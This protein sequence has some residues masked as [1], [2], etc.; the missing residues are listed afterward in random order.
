MIEGRNQIAVEWYT[1]NRTSLSMVWYGT[2]A[3]TSTAIGGQQQQMMIMA[4]K[5]HGGQ[6]FKHLVLLGDLIPGINYRKWSNLLRRFSESLVSTSKEYKV[7]SEEM[8]SDV[9]YFKVPDHRL[10]SSSSSFT[11]SSSHL[12]RPK[13]IDPEE[14]LEAD[15]QQLEQVFAESARALDGVLSQVLDDLRRVD[16]LFD[17]G[18]EEDDGEEEEEAEVTKSN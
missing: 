18:L 9:H 11:F 4:D 2:R 15:D 8:V 1:R 3:F 7:G 5:E 17:G 13:V 16:S 10:T 12:F 14:L 6:L